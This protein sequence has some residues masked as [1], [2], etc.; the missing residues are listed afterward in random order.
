MS[1]NNLL[2]SLGERIKVVVCLQTLN[3]FQL[4][5]SYTLYKITQFATH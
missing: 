2:H 5:L 4:D 3:E 1:V